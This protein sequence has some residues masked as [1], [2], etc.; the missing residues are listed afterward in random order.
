LLAVLAER[1][2]IW[3]GIIIGLPYGFAGYFCTHDRFYDQPWKA[4]LSAGIV[5]FLFVLLGIYSYKRARR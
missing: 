5:W 2:S 3:S 4:F 1:P